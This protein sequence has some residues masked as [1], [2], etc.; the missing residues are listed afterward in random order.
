MEDHKWL[1]W[2]ESRQAARD[3]RVAAR[4]MGRCACAEPNAHESLKGLSR[5][6][7]MSRAADEIEERSQGQF[8]HGYYGA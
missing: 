6:L 1:D 3:I 2:K 7:A 5:M 8:V 4:E